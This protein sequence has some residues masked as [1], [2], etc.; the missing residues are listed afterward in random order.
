MSGEKIK[1]DDSGITEVERELVED[2]AR[3]PCQRE[4]STPRVR[5]LMVVCSFLLTFVPSLTQMSFGILLP[6]L[7]QVF[8]ISH[9][10][11]GVIGGLRI[12]LTT[13]GGNVSLLTLVETAR[14]HERGWSNI[15]YQNI[16]FANIAPI[17]QIQIAI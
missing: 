5:W 17:S 6:E 13:G 8:N 2:G 16:T 9:T 10:A 3:L 11:A 4:P 14:V 1:T 15:G 7:R 12:G